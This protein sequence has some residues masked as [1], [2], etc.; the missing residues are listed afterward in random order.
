MNAN[1]PA[2]PCP[3]RAEHYGLSKREYAAIQIAAGMA[4]YGDENAGNY[5]PTG[6]ALQA[7]AV[8]DMLLTELDKTKGDK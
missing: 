5:S 2:F 8:A 1:Q 6:I 4:A 7:V 3:D